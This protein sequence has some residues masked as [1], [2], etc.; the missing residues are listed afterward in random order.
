MSNYKDQI[1][2]LSPELKNYVSALDT[3]F[4]IVRTNYVRDKVFEE[5]FSKLTIE[6]KT[7]VINLLINRIG[8]FHVSKELYS[9]V[10]DQQ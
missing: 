6:A 4:L 5:V 8:N 1:S 2:G 9:K 10:L 7:E 3:L